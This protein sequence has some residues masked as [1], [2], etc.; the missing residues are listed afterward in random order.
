MNVIYHAQ[1]AVAEGIMFLVNM[2]SIRLDNLTTIVIGH[3]C[4]AYCVFYL[5][6]FGTAAT[7]NYMFT[8]NIIPSATAI[9]A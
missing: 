6:S 7:R 4:M 2:V 8:R 3:F 5:T 9:C 1:I